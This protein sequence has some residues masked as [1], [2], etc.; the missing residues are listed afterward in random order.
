MSK[1]APNNGVHMAQKD[2]WTWCPIAGLKTETTDGCPEQWV[3]YGC[4]LLAGVPQI[5]GVEMRQIRT[6]MVHFRVSLV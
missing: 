4:T 1:Q 2:F 5:I 6:E 3:V